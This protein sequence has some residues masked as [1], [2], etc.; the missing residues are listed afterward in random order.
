MGTE[1]YLPNPSSFSLPSRP[2]NQ[3]RNPLTHAR[4][5]RHLMPTPMIK[6]PPPVFLTK[7]YQLHT[8]HILRVL[9]P[10]DMH[11]RY[12]DLQIFWERTKI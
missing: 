5:P 4:P 11:R 12:L 7:I 8:S 6:R 1:L 9:S 3:L 10:I 2:L